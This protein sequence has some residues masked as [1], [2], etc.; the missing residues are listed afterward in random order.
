MLSF[1]IMQGRLTPSKNR[2]IQFFPFENWQKEF[3]DA[4]EIGLNEI[5]WIFD[6]EKYE[7][8]PIFTDA[9]RLRVRETVANTGIKI[10]SICFD[11]FMRVPFY[12]IQGDEKNKMFSE[13][14]EMTY[15]VL[16]SLA[17]LGGRLLEIP[18][19]DN[20]SVKTIEEEKMAV[21]YVQKSAEM[22][23]E[24]GIKIG[25]ETDFPPGKFKKFLESIGGKY[26]YANFDSG[27]SSGLGYDAL[28]EIGSLKERIYNVHIKDR[29]YQGTTVKLGTGSADFNKV[30]S[31]LKEVGY[32]N[33]FILQAARGEDGKEK[34]NIVQQ[35][36]FVKEYLARYHIG[37]E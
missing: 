13:N 1:G 24:F 2:G 17:E 33:S 36:N 28:E 3:Y 31:A 9:R 34:D 29:V 15:R 37:D 21:E 35:L 27:N 25:L 18:M 26:V 30:F 11:Y 20:S 32:Q 14:C 4:I 12:K 6:Y 10:N 19:V 5:E 7:E 16:N 8:N 22:A 23:S